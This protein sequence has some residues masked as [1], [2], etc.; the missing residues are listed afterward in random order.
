[1]V[2]YSFFM[3]MRIIENIEIV[4]L[5]D[6]G[7]GVARNEGQ[8]LFI[9]NAIPGD[10]V[11]VKLTSRRKGITYA[12]VVDFLLESDARVVPHCSHFGT[13]GGCQYQHISYQK[14][15]DFKQNEVLQAFT[16]LARMSAV[17]LLPIIPSDKLQYYRNKLEF[18]FSAK[19]WLDRYDIT[20]KQ[21]D[22]DMRGLGFHIPKMFDKVL[23]LEKCYF[24]SPPSNDIRLAIRD[25]CIEAGW[26]FYNYRTHTGFLR[27][28]VIR[29]AI[30]D[31]WM[32]ILVFAYYDHQRIP[33]LLDFIYERFPMITSLIYIVNEK[34]N[35]SY[36]DLSYHVYKGNSFLLEELDGLKFKVGPLSFFQVNRD[37]ALLLYRKIVEFAEFRGNETIYDLYTGAG[38]IALF[39]A[40]YVGRV[41]GIENVPTAIA[42]ANYNMA[43]NKISNTVF[44]TGDIAATLTHDFIRENG[45][46]DIIITDPPRSGMHDKVIKMLLEIEAEKI[47][48]V[49]CNP[50]TQARDVQ[51]LAEKYELVQLQPV[52]MFPHTYHVESIGLLRRKTDFRMND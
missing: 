6:K 27:N 3:L 28:L 12:E 20:D 51:M 39:I 10:R 19:K 49:S 13:C 46:P 29:N 17:P 43:E 44:Y 34:K 42:D 50:S 41:I 8:V 47:I 7:H 14:Q 36:S 38:A 1:M 2:N 35:D 15:L 25:F 24:Q 16:R 26:E 11:T 22:I 30:N 18:T 32:V 40:R 52:D 37:Q 33:E 45:S 4:D 23:D 5:A 9:K 21:D 48:Y 31:Q